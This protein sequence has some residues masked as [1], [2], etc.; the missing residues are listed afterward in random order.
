MQASARS[1]NCSTGPSPQASLVD[2]QASIMDIQ[3]WTWGVDPVH[4]TVGETLTGKRPSWRVIMGGGARL[5]RT[6]T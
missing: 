3:V 4:R 6:A 5:L 2:K 1:P